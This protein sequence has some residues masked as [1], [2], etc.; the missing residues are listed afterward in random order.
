[1][2]K[3]FKKTFCMFAIL[4]IFVGGN[5]FATMTPTFPNDIKFSRGVS[6]CCY[7]VD[8]SASSYTSQINSAADNWVDTGYGWNP[9]YMT[10][11]ASNYGTHID[12][13]GKTSST[14]SYLNNNAL[15][16]T[17]FWNGDGTLV[18]PFGS[19]PTYNYY[20]SEIVLNLDLS[21]SYDIRTA[22]HEMGH[23]FGLAHTENSY[24]IMC[25][26]ITDT[27]VTTV[28]QC[29]HDAINYLYN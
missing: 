17:S 28:Q 25:P 13:Y 15:G 19:Y 20:Y 4:T 26:N 8:S 23:A 2:K 7:Y 12:F 22:K 3:F 24:S 14:E 27:Y 29:D 21:D 9:I 11:V 16:F 6:N 5:I 18:A 10:P 1:M